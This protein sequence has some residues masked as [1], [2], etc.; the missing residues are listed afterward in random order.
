MQRQVLLTRIVAYAEQLSSRHSS[1]LRR[2]EVSTKP[3]EETISCVFTTSRGTEWESTCR[4]NGQK[5]GLCWQH[6]KLLYGHEVNSRAT[7]RNCQLCG[8]ARSGILSNWSDA[9]TTKTTDPNWRQRLTSSRIAAR[10]ERQERKI[11]ER[12]ERE[13]A[14]RPAQCEGL[15]PNGGRCAKEAQKDGLCA[16]HWRKRS[17]HE[18]WSMSSSCKSAES[19]AMTRSQDGM[20]L[21]L[22]NNKS[23]GRC[24]D[25][26]DLA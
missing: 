13:L 1:A 25:P 5:D 21:A 6:W 23:V 26:A 22:A 4:A 11:Q 9:C 14:R 10:L 3:I 24:F 7:H 18:Y 15:K 16:V 20:S 12:R 2:I 19:E 8:E 17:G